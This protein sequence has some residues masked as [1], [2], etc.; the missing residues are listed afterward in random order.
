MMDRTDRHFRFLMRQITRR[1]LLYTEMVTAQAILRGPTDKLLRFDPQEH[2]VALQL[3]GD[4]PKM[5]AEA[6]RRGERYGYDEINLN[7]GC[8]SERVQQGRFGVCLMAEP[9]RV[10]AIVSAIQDA[11]RVPVTVKHR[12]GFD[13]LDTYDHLLR[14]VERVAE[15]GCR[16]FSVHARK[17]WLRGLS[18]KENRNLPPLRYDDVYRLKRARPDLVIEING[19]IRSLDA[20]ARHLESVDAVMIGRAAYDDPYMFAPVDRTFFGDD[21][22]VRSRGDVVVQLVP[23]V[24]RHL[25]DGG[26]LW[27]I[28]RHMFG[29][30]AG[31]K[32]ARAFRRY[33]SEHAHRP[34]AG[35]EVLLDAVARVNEAEGSPAHSR[36]AF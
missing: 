12:I 1:T 3:G 22:G 4:D 2:P 13:D 8:P 17:A 21:S 15:T 16:R 26:R 34:G 18:P 24:E 32:G 11:V 33:L 5:L 6:A 31:R 20:V 19:G 23:Y 25:A 14:F 28:A 10:A 7:V 35:P 9:D 36:Q 30:F 27:P 29:L